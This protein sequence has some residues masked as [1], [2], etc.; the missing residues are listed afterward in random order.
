MQRPGHSY[1]LCTVI[2]MLIRYCYRLRVRVWVGGEVSLC[3][4]KIP[5][6]IFFRSRSRSRSRSRLR[7]HLRVR[8]RVRLPLCGERGSPTKTNPSRA[9][10]KCCAIPFWNFQRDEWFMKDY[11]NIE[12]VTFE[13]VLRPIVIKTHIFEIAPRCSPPKPGRRRRVFILK[14]SPSLRCFLYMCFCPLPEKR[15]FYLVL[16]LYSHSIVLLFHLMVCWK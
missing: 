1:Y 6:T 7:G 11:K 9:E 5:V 14:H 2:H 3:G 15:Y 13:R 10:K 8:G 12:S 4:G 16:D